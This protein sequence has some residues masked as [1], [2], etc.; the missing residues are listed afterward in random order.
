M[1]VALG[2]GSITSW[3]LISSTSSSATM[4]IA[5]TPQTVTLVVGQIK[6]FELTRMYLTNW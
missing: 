6:K 3:V 2:V 1:W 5:S 4:A